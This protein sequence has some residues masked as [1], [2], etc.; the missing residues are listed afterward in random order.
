MPESSDPSPEQQRLLAITRAVAAAEQAETAL[1]D[2]L[3]A[4]RD[5][6]DPEDPIREAL[7]ARGA[8]ARTAVRELVAGLGATY[9]AA[10]AGAASKDHVAAWAAPDGPAPAPDAARRLRLAHRVWRQVADS[11]GDAATRAWFLAANPALAGDS[12]LVAIKR[13]RA[14]AIDAAVDAARSG[15]GAPDAAS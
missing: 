6:G 4:A 13:D 14:Q 5:A 9:V 12:P 10:V 15:R 7:A 3:D 2:A 11:R 1:Q 8:G